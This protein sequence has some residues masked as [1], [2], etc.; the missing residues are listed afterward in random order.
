MKRTLLNIFLILALTLSL[1]TSV[2]AQ[3]AEPIDPFDRELPAHIEGLKLDRP[4]ELDGTLDLSLTTN[5]GPTEVIIRLSADSV[6]DAKGKGLA[7]GKAKKAAEAQQD[8]YKAG[9]SF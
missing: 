1:A 3:E 7:L 6:A 5:V 4:V 9:R 2:F 8:S